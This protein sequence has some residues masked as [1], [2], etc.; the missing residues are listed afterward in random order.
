MAATSKTT[1]TA[2]KQQD[3]GMRSRTEPERPLTP[4][5]IGQRDA[6]PD[7]D[8]AAAAAE[9]TPAEGHAIAQQEQAGDQTSK[10]PSWLRYA[11][12][13]AAAVV[14]LFGAMVGIRHFQWA[15]IH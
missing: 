14:I 9:P 8:G 15:A 3:R 4:E 13:A 12:F 2:A 10:R 11:A 6:S 5:R 7:G 1:R